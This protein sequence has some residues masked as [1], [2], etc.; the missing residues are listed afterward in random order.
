MGQSELRREGGHTGAEAST[1]P[2]RHTEVPS[3]FASAKGR[4]RQLSRNDLKL[5][6]FPHLANCQNGGS[7]PVQ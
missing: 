2:G 6:N 5:S 4:C 7:S 3:Q 1:P